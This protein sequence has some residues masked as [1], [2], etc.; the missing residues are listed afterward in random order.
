[1]QYNNKIILQALFLSPL[2]TQILLAVIFI[3]MNK[4]YDIQS[5]AT[6]LG[7]TGII[8]II[9]CIIVIPIAYAI[10]IWLAAKD[11]LNFFSIVS[12]S[13]FI[14]LIVTIIGYLVFIGSFPNQLWKLF[15]NWYFYIIAVFTGCCYWS[16]LNIFSKNSQLIS[17]ITDKAND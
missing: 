2:I 13:L 14:W 16:F 1:M 4:T 10:S 5:L 15:S 9:Y 11:W 12:G 6:V 3:T 8:Y 17:N 7:I